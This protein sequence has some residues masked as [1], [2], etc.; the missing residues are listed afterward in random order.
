MATASIPT[1]PQAPSAPIVSTTDVDKLEAKTSILK[2]KNVGCSA[3][4]AT[5]SM[6]TQSLRSQ[7]E[8]QKEAEP[9]PEGK[10]LIS[11]VLAVGKEW[12]SK[13]KTVTEYFEQHKLEVLTLRNEFGVKK[14]T[15]GKMLYVPQ[16]NGTL[17]AMYWS[18]FVS[19]AFGVSERHINR[20]LGITE[21]PNPPDPTKSKNY[22]AGFAAGQEATMRE[23]VQ[24]PA[25][26][27]PFSKLDK[28]AP[29]TYFEQFKYGKETFASEL[30]AMVVG[31]FEPTDTDEIVQAF[32][33]EVKRQQ[34]LR[35]AEAARCALDK[36]AEKE[37]RQ[38]E[39]AAEKAART[40]KN[41][42]GVKTTNKVLVSRIGDTHEFGVFPDSCDEHTAANALT[43]GTKQACE[44]ERDRL[45]TKR[46]VNA[47]SLAILPGAANTQVPQTAVSVQ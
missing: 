10:A 11:T 22:K 7:N 25:G 19:L 26:A 30:A 1:P 38:T 18:D 34:E 3:G 42:P 4:A 37:S 33:K 17:E 46:A 39:A 29:Y 36:L 9:T 45:N 13:R 27:Q 21:P 47:E 24:A 35:N 41:E 43:I 5:A 20:L 44:A 32:G 8:I 40:K 16:T 12:Q 6:G 23:Q 15:K 14:G 31:M 2:P 28:S